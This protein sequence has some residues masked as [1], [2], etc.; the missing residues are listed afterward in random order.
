MSEDSDDP[1]RIII[2]YL[3]YN[4]PLFIRPLRSDLESEKNVQAI[5]ATITS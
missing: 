2:E 4:G 1:L 3:R 5:G